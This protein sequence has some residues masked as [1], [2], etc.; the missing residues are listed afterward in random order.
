[1]AELSR[2]KKRI[3]TLEDGSFE[4]TESEVSKRTKNEEE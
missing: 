2:Q 4:I 1:M 3:S